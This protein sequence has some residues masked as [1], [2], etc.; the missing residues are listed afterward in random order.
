MK[1]LIN[2]KAAPNRKSFFLLFLSLK[3]M[4]QLFNL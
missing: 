4:E 1:N 2:P 3:E